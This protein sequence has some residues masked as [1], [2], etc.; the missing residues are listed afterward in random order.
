MAANTVNIIYYLMPLFDVYCAW[1]RFDLVMGFFSSK[2]KRRE[3][4]EMVNKYI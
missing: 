2:R 3:R 1:G 4:K